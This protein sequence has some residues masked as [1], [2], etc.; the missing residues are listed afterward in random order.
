L[1]TYM[2]PA[3]SSPDLFVTRCQK[4]RAPFRQ[5]LAAGACSSARA[6]RGRAGARD[7]RRGGCPAPRVSRGSMAPR[8]PAATAS[9]PTVGSPRGIPASEGRP[10]R[11]F[12]Q[13]A[14]SV[15]SRNAFSLSIEACDAGKSMPSKRGRGG[16]RGRSRSPVAK[17]A[18]ASG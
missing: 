5:R 4:S 8:A 14:G 2:Q 3:A 7:A 10:R 1:S 9:C 15:D 13:V 16:L 6:R 17:Q 18:K 12:V 11:G